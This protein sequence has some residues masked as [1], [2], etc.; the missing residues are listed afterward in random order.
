MKIKLLNILIL[1]TI[2]S[3]SA[4]IGDKLIGQNLN[5]DK[6]IFICEKIDFD[7]LSI[8]EYPKMFKKFIIVK[9]KNKYG[10]LNEKKQLILPIEYDS[11]EHTHSAYW[12]VISKNKLYGVVSDE[13]VLTVPIY[14]EHIEDDFKGSKNIDDVGFI[15]QKNLKLGSIDFHNNIIIPI[16][17]DGISN[18]VEYGPDAHY[19][20]KGNFYGLINHHTGELIIPD[21]YDGLEV[22]RENIVEVKKNGLY[23]VLNFEN[24]VVLPCMYN[25]LY[26]D[27]NWMGLEKYHEDIICA[28]SKTEKFIFDVNGKLKSTELLNQVDK[29]GKFHNKDYNEY[30]YHLIECMI[31]P[32]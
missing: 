21:I 12:F 20:K 16:E 7:S 19:V 17:Y 5:N 14:Y 15:V 26:V 25:T 4:C 2:Y 28:S 6:N 1:L 11:I 32:K 13:G 24:K 9:Q 30:G 10:L 3:S 18:W 8:V 22:H 27:L 31:F 23:G 29:K